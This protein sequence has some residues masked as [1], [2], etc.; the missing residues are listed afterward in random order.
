VAT[1]ADW[2]DASGLGAVLA[3]ALGAALLAAAVGAALLAAAVGAALLAAAVGAALLAAAVGAGLAVGAAVGTGVG[4][5]VG[6]GVAAALQAP[7]A[8]AKTAAKA[9]TGCRRWFTYPPP[10]DEVSKSK[11]SSASAGHGDRFPM[12]APGAL[13][14]GR[15]A[16][17]SDLSRWY[18]APYRHFQRSGA[19]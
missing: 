8:I 4:A 11:A 17:K 2:P 3:E 16:F 14:A 9:N 5:T 13:A 18:L 10:L 19:A 6:D 15:Y 7:S 1:G 12:R